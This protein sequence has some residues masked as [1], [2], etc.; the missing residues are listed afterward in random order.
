MLTEKSG[1]PRIKEALEANEWDNQGDANDGIDQDAIDDI[2]AAQDPENMDFG[3]GQA[4]DLESLKKAIWAD[5][6]TADAE[7]EEQ[8]AKKNRGQED[9]D[10]D[11]V[12]IGDE[13][14]AK[15]EAMMRKLQAAREAGETMSETQRRK[16]A[17]KAVQEVMREL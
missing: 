10:T 2:S 17:A 13:D 16:M 15:V 5:A 14:V 12:D 4:P 3:L 7:E 1:I 9:R 6:T 11:K 8:D